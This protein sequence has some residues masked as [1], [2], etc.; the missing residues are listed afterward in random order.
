MPSTA[1]A[2]GARIQKDIMVRML[3]RLML[4]NPAFPA[5]DHTCMSKYDI[6]YV[7][8][9]ENSFSCKNDVPFNMNFLDN[10]LRD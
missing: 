7:Q 10:T 4:S 6:I 5:E 1:I 8:K 3:K 2:I 9:I